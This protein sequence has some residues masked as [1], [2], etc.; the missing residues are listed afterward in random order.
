[1]TVG[2][3]AEGSIKTGI[4]HSFILMVI[5]FIISAGANLFFGAA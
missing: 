5:A 1:L 2:K 4:K 3:L